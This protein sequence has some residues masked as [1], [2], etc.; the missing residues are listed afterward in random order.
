MIS[1]DNFVDESSPT[2]AQKN[3]RHGRR[4]SRNHALEA[5]ERERLRDALKGEKNEEKKAR[6]RARL[7]PSDD[8]IDDDS[9]WTHLRNVDIHLLDLE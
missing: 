7:R 3:I 2:G 1:R 9:D 6:H 4:R 8:E 5:E